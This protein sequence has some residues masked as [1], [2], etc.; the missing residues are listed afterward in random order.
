MT[1]K[2]V[3]KSFEEEQ[4]PYY[5]SKYDDV[6]DADVLNAIGNPK[7][8]IL[9]FIALTSDKAIDHLEAIAQKS[10]R[11]TGDRFGKVIQLYAP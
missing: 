11:I 7:P 6:S 3:F 1:F 5:L 2:N 9:D 8:G 10:K 4:L